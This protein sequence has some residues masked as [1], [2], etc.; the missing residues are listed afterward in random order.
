MLIGIEPTPD[1]M[2]TTM[3]MIEPTSTLYEGDAN[4]DGKVNIID[5]IFVRNRLNL[6]YP[7][8]SC[9][10]CNADQ[11]RDD[12]VNI[13]DTLYVR[14][15][16]DPAPLVPRTPIVRV[17]AP[18][19]LAPD[20]LAPDQTFW[21]TSPCMQTLSFHF[22]YDSSPLDL[23]FQGLITG[24]GGSG[25]PLDFWEWSIDGGTPDP[26]EA[27]TCTKTGDT[28]YTF[29]MVSEPPSSVRY[30]LIGTLYKDIEQTLVALHV[31]VYVDLNAEAD[32]VVELVANNRTYQ[33]T[34]EDRPYPI[35]I[36]FF[37][38][39]SQSHTIIDFNGLTGHSEDCWNWELPTADP[40]NETI[41]CARYG[42]DNT[43]FIFTGN[44]P[45][46][47][48]SIIYTFNGTL[49]TDSSHVQ[50]LFDMVA[51]VTILPPARVNLPS[52]AQY[53]GDTISIK[54]PCGTTI[55]IGYNGTTREIDFEPLIG[56]DYE[57]LPEEFW[58]WSIQTAAPEGADTWPSEPVDGYF[59]FSGTFP[60]EGGVALYTFTGRMYPDIEHLGAP[61]TL[62]VTV[63]VYDTSEFW[64]QFG[65]GETDSIMFNSVDANG[66]TIFHA[67]TG[68]I[69][70]GG[71]LLDSGLTLD[72]AC[73]DNTTL[74]IDGTPYDLAQ[75]PNGPST[76]SIPI[77]G[78]D[79][80]P[81]Q[82]Y[83]KTMTDDPASPILIPSIGKSYPNTGI[84]CTP[85]TR[86][87]AKYIYID[88]NLVPECNPGQT[89][90][91]E[92]TAIIP[93]NNDDDNESQWEDLIESPVQNENDLVE[94][95][96][97]IKFKLFDPQCSRS[98]P[99]GTLNLQLPDK[100]KLWKDA[101]KTQSIPSDA[102][103]CDPQ[104][105]DAER[106]YIFNC[107]TGYQEF[108]KCAGQI[109]GT[110]CNENPNRNK[111]PP[112]EPSYWTLL[113]G[114]SIS[115]CDDTAR[116]LSEI[117]EGI[118]LEGV[119]VGE[120]QIK[121]VFNVNQ[122]LFPTAS[123]SDT[124]KIRVIGFDLDIDSDNNNGYDLD[125]SDYEDEIEDDTDKP[126]KIVFAN[127]KDR[128]GDGIPDFADGFDRDGIADN[129]DDT[130]GGARF[131]KVVL[132]LPYQA[133][134]N[135]TIQISYNASDP[136]TV[137]YDPGT[138]TYAPATGN[139]RLWLKDGALARDKRN[140][141]A[142]NEDDRG[143][144]VAP[145]DY[146]AEMLGT[147]GP[148]TVILY[149][150]GINP[151]ESLGGCRI[152]A[153]AG[154]FATQYDAVRTT[155]LVVDLLADT[156][157]D[158]D[159][160]SDDEA[161]KDTW[162]KGPD[163]RGAIILPNCDKDGSGVGPDNWP[164]GAD[165]DGIPP[166]DDA[167]TE[168][169]SEDDIADIGELLVS[170]FGLPTLPDDLK[171]TLTLSNPD[172]ED[173]YFSTVPPEK[174]VRVFLPS[175]ELEDGSL[176]IADGDH[177]I[178]GPTRGASVEFVKT[179]TGSQ[180]NYSI[181]VGQDDVIFGIE[182]IELGAMVDVTMT[183]Q[184]SENVLAT[185]RVRIRVAPFV[186]SDNTLPVESSY[187]AL[188][189][190]NWELRL[191]LYG[192][193]GED[194]YEFPLGEDTWHQDGYEIGYAKAPYGELAV[195]LVSPRATAGEYPYEEELL[196]IA[197]NSILSSDI[198]VCWSLE[199]LSWDGFS[200]GG[201]LECNPYY[202]AEEPGEFFYGQSLLANIQDFFTAQDVNP[203]VATN[204]NTD[205]LLVGHV[206]EV[207]SFCADSL[208][209]VVA[210]PEVGWALLVWAN[211]IDPNATMHWDMNFN[212]P[213]GITV[214]DIL[215]TGSGLYQGGNEVS[216]RDF[217]LLT[218]D[219][220]YVMS[221]VNLPQ[222]RD[223]T[224][225]LPSPESVPLPGE[226][227]TG[228]AFLSKAGAFVAFFP[229]AYT[230]YYQITF[231]SATEYIVSWREEGQEF[232]EDD[233]PGNVNEDCVFPT[234][235][236]FIFRHWW[237]G[238]ANAGDVFTFHADP[239]CMTIEMPV[240]FMYENN[241]ALAYTI[242]HVNSLVDGGTVFTGDPYGP[243][244]LQED[245]L[246]EYVSLAF[247]WAGYEDVMF[248]DSRTYH[249]AMGDVHCGTNARR[250]IPSYNWWE[251]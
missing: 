57:H 223:T 138:G 33:I 127:T 107:N 4:R 27:I 22:T 244:V 200:D 106:T 82:L 215:A 42:T 128:D 38:A 158:S 47:K 36:G 51:E 97:S 130:C 196:K 211:M 250:S 6:M 184:L 66:E 74:V 100:V 62:S 229:N 210:D 3:G 126:G 43:Q 233:E 124:D 58:E 198:G 140:A 118:Y 241:G 242:D 195:C 21:I 132:D 182:G 218:D 203:P 174:R 9:D 120:S 221:S 187:V 29:T 28:L 87:K 12:K 152:L 240:V 119:K 150:E 5:S 96:V 86:L 115:V 133:A 142:Q 171:I 217:N 111:Y 121:A 50:K 213:S 20:P 246:S 37:C 207:I 232:L 238:T 35:E 25:D 146:K 243:V 8:S 226:T 151:T 208:H 167:N 93:L 220:R 101:T 206:D 117:M 19:L 178:L 88:I 191:A 92:G 39:D 169:D 227:N 72:I 179:P 164:G 199:S 177:E 23:D 148:G 201:N 149:A 160:D 212:G 79:N 248:V 84:Y 144:Y 153:S 99:F 1:G 105:W 109:Y 69:H 80:K 185:D 204:V 34:P 63:E 157:R 54:D 154:T 143:D 65:S 116:P 125:R 16:L 141:N 234:A 188:D 170:G 41:T 108:V 249:D 102:V 131:Y 71:W 190:Y 67:A 219:G 113:D 245:I 205:W 98:Y 15:R 40:E 18:D 176:V 147:D 30:T 49:Y 11:N 222:I 180:E 155:V 32:P 91:T 159:I 52:T 193:Y 24:D 81:F 197:H 194:A 129:D 173:P 46:N 237:S 135:K 225:H 183:V 192:L 134:D 76:I 17:L 231:S 44:L 162:T 14:N 85:E 13:M 95:K 247:I 216:L 136:K 48:E 186:L 2:I 56:G 7:W 251:N 156:D 112:T 59:V 73:H 137:T 189:S 236:C 70:F 55:K 123:A 228:T 145:G 60:C 110:D 114:Y 163:G 209:T 104:P 45:S 94:F 181:F 61:V 26:G 77:G 139:L 83:P 103:W 53:I 10:D 68:T 214:G 168:V 64:M 78:Q 172:D 166:D 31:V 90:C 161:D 75:L 89:N 202:Q 224:L 122:P 239:A 230:R 235:L 175:L 165:W